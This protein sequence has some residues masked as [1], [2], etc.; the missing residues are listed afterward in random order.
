MK[1]V[2]TFGFSI[3]YFLIAF[4]FCVSFSITTI[5]QINY[6]N[7]ANVNPGELSF[8]N[9]ASLQVDKLRLINGNGQSRGAVWYNTPQFVKS[10]FVCTFSFQINTPQIAA[11]PPM[12]Y[13]PQN[14]ADG[15]AFLIHT[16]GT[17]AIGAGGGGLGYGRGGADS[18]AI[19]YSLAVEF[20]TYKNVELNDPDGNHIS[21]HHV[22]QYYNDSNE[23][24]TYV[25][26]KTNVVPDFNNG[27]VHTARIEYNGVTQI[28]KVFVDDF[29]VPKLTS[30]VI[31]FGN[32]FQPG[33]DTAIIGFTAGAALESNNHEILS[34]SYSPTYPAVVY[35]GDAVD[36]DSTG[37]NPTTVALSP[38]YHPGADTVTQFNTTAKIDTAVLPDRA[39][40][41]WAKYYFP[42]NIKSS[43]PLPLV[44]L[45]HGNHGSCGVL[46][47]STSGYPRNDNGN[48]YTT[49]G[50]CMA[51]TVVSPSHRGYDYLA[52]KLA[53][54]GYIVASVNANRGITPANGYAVVPDF[55]EYPADDPFIWARGR[56]VLRHLQ[57]LSEWNEG[58]TQ[59]ISQPPVPG[60]VKNNF[61]G[62][63]G[64]KITTG[65]V[66]IKIKSLGRM[67]RK[68]NSQTHTVKIVR[69]SDNVDVASVSIP[70][71]NWNQGQFKYATL[72]SA[73][74]LSPNTA[75]YIVSQETS[76]GDSW[77]D[78]NTTLVPTSVATINGKVSSLNSTTW[79]TTGAVV[80]Q[81]FGTVDFIYEAVPSFTSTTT[82]GTARNNLSKWMGMKITT[83]AT[84]VTVKS[85]GR[86][87]KTGNA[88][89][90]RVRIIKVSD[91]SVAAE[92]S[93]AMTGGVNG[94]YKYVNLVTPVNLTA[95]TA[96]YVVSEEANNLDE[97]YDSNTTVTP[98][99]VAA[100]NG[101]VAGIMDGTTITWNNAGAVAN[102]SYGPVNFIY[103]TSSPFITAQTLGT[104][105]TGLTD[106]VGMK[107]TTGSESLTVNSLGRMF[108]TGNTQIHK[109]R[110][111][112]ISDGATIS[113]VSVPMT[114]G[115]NGQF[116]YVNLASPVTLAPNTGYYIASEETGTDQWYDSNT[117]VATSSLATIN[118]RVSGFKIGTAIT[119][120]ETG[121]VANKAYGPVDFTY[122]ASSTPSALGVNLKGKIDFSNVGLMGHSRGGEGVRA[123]KFLYETNDLPWTTGIVETS[124]PW[125]DS[126]FGRIRSTMKIKGIFEIAP[127]DN[128]SPVALNTSNTTRAVVLP[129][130]DGDVF[131]LAGVKPFD[132]MYRNI[133]ETLD[134]PKSTF[135][136]YGTNHNFYNTQWQISE[137]WA[138]CIGDG[139]T[140]L[141]ENPNLPSDMTTI[142]GNGYG[143][144]LQQKVSLSS[145]LAFFR[146]NVGAS[147]NPSL[148]QTFDSRYKLP[149][150]LSSV[151][152]LERG[153]TQSLDAS[154]AKKF[155]DLVFDVADVNKNLC[156]PVIVTNP[157]K[158]VVCSSYPGTTVQASVKTVQRGQF[159]TTFF[160]QDHDARLLTSSVTWDSAFGPN[161]YFQV[162]A[163]NGTFEDAST[164]QTLDFRISRRR[165]DLESSKLL[166][167]TSNLIGSDN[168]T[169]LSIQLVMN[170]GTISAPVSLSKYVRLLGP[171]GLDNVL[172]NR[173]ELHPIL[174]TVRVPLSDFSGATLTQVKGVRFIFNDQPKGAIFLS[175]LRFLK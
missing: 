12:G 30:P 39:T 44:V 166:P 15:F 80:N 174:Q 145:F 89:T 42:G 93:V 58:V 14:G 65:S 154:K 97:W 102:K 37:P 57:R 135:F 61:A 64:M 133:N 136:V 40:E 53:S 32:I 2:Q 91:N 155:N 68:T 157:A 79:D 46:A 35:A 83:G 109:V 33:L 96:Y 149:V 125:S 128:A 98:T 36:A 88:Q 25:M 140:P 126:A 92:V 147:A 13:T 27:A 59:F 94:Q 165:D 167:N 106:W 18:D 151:T 54:W 148:N 115:V 81:S 127:T 3:K 164:Y 160:D 55:D 129:A 105:T 22:G 5:A 143:S 77:S 134:F 86:M 1:N 108:R 51:G 31:N 142:T 66:P 29:T 26:A 87:F 47:A 84:A 8:V 78:S 168:F 85:L 41:I 159:S 21:I 163:A 95:N 171:V 69:V 113:E 146:A 50:S 162:N 131:N 153:F 117:T 122:Q 49:S 17:N 144:V 118:G 141:F 9:D 76:G 101:R 139:N 124:N 119:W 52:E 110:I 99:A 4:I 103:A 45:L 132:R 72:T 10:G 20:D 112:R 156:N 175:G 74:T 56:L 23:N 82:L 48:T 19:A 120:N 111:T 104:A 73:V 172:D 75:Y 100:V 121:G 90:H 116:K 173:G 38:E 16:W 114:G 158:N 60:T 63:L 28:M 67:Y 107:V 150:T 138:R 170:N 161:D 7:F 152:K 62:W 137:P 43:G 71:T 130:C 169:R 24:G 34:W 70:M 11:N 6:Q 123:A